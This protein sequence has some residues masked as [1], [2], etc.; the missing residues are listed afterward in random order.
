VRPLDYEGEDRFEAG[1]DSEG[2][3]REGRE[4]GRHFGVQAF[5]YLR[6]ELNFRRSS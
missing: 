3:G 5:R 6:C 1:R 4:G 2:G